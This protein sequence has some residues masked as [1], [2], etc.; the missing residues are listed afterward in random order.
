MNCLL[1]F[2]EEF[3][4]EIATVGGERAKMLIARHALIVGLVIRAGVLH[5]SLGKAEILDISPE[6][7]RIRFTAE[8]A[9]P[10]RFPLHA[11]IAVPRPQTIKK[12]IGLGAVT[13]IA[14]IDFVRAERTE[15]S[16]LTSHALREEDIREESYLGLEQAIDTI[17]PAINVY[18]RF[19]P[20]IEDI[21]P[22]KKQGKNNGSEE[23]VA[24]IAHPDASQTLEEVLAIP[25]HHHMKVGYLALGPEAG[26][27]EYELTAFNKL[28]FIA[29]SLG[30]RMLRVEQALGVCIGALRSTFVTST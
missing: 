4:G 16:Y 2:P 29:F 3:A 17:A 30:P 27:S 18:P 12:V 28:G 11:I 24:L 21:F 25:A 15:K 20:Y 1:L 23:I 5:G 14:S 13:G 6:Q 26:W 10:E 7:V 19:H 9:A 22:Q 8:K